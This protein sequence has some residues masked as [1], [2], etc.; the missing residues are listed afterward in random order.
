MKILVLGA[1]DSS[2]LG[3]PIICDCVASWLRSHFS[4][5]QVVIK[6]VLLRRENSVADLQKTRRYWWRN[7]LRRVITRIL[8]VDVVY[9]QY[10]RWVAKDKDYMDMLCAGGYDAVVFAGGQMF[11]DRYALFLAAYIQRFQELNIPVFFNAC[12]TGPAYSPKIAR[13]LKQTLE[14]PN[15]QYVSS[16]DDAVLVSEKYASCRETYDP[17]LIAAAVY[18]V[19][20][21][22]N[23]DTIGLGVIFNQEISEKKQTKFWRKLVQELDRRG[24]KWQFFTNGDPLDM[25]YAQSLLATMPG[26]RGREEKLLH[27]RDIEP[28]ALVRTI[29]GYRSIISF[30]LHSHIL[31]ASLDVPSVGIVWDKKL[32]FFFEKMGHLERC[33][34]VG[35]DPLEVLEALAWAEREGHNRELLTNQAQFAMEQLIQAVT[36]VVPALTEGNL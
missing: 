3:D 31:A 33:F 28:K 12:G 6:D 13:R 35:S 27:S 16:R 8:H 9:G 19:S 17:A 18:G 11:M 10:S 23:A 32:P 34:Q 7:R 29:A 1:Y 30:R 2:N 21:A 20:R 5:A 26:C 25:A 22:E 36:N 24:E 4:C 14:S 15:V